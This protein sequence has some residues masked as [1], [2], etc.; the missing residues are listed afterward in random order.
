[1]F[2]RH[3]RPFVLLR[4]NSKT[5]MI[6]KYM[7]LYYTTTSVLDMQGFI[8]DFLLG[9]GKFLLMLPATRSVASGVRCAHAT[10]GGSGGMLP[11]EILKN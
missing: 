8:Q 3:C 7:C 1:M 10:L 2:Q 11:Q 6:C 5:D 9:G 4:L